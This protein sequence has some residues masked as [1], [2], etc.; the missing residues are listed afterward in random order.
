MPLIVN[1]GR[2][3]NVSEELL[4]ESHSAS[5]LHELEHARVS[6]KC[7]ASSLKGRQASALLVLVNTCIQC[8]V[9]MKQPYTVYG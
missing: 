1:Y 5:F 9:L 3:R 6:G 7:P 2:P 8:T 4:A